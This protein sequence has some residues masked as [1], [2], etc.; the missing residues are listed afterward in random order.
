VTNGQRL[1][2]A[3]NIEYNNPSGETRILFLGDSFTF[4][5]TSTGEDFV[6]ATERCLRQELG[7]KTRC[8][9]MGAPDI[10][11]ALELIY[12]LKAGRKYGA[13]VVV[14]QICGNDIADDARDSVFRSRNDGTLEETPFRMSIRQKLIATSWLYSWLSEHSSFLEAIK[15]NIPTIW[16]NAEAIGRQKDAYAS[17]GFS[18]QVPLTRKVWTKLI[19][20]IREDGAIPVFLLVDEPSKD[21]LMGETYTIAQE[22]AN[23]QGVKVI[24]PVKALKAHFGDLQKARISARDGHWNVAANGVVGRFVCETVREALFEG[25]V[26]N[27]MIAPPSP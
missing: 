16:Y 23:G 10:G 4:G 26:G 9:N 2:E 1:R 14:V 15:M 24:C 18:A 27:S 25:A 20:S 8:I 17:A 19:E 21:S 3:E 11:A 13:A 22:V 5:A 7:A 6:R 12:Y